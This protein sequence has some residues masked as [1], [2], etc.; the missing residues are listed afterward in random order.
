VERSRLVDCDRALTS[1]A[2]SRHG[3]VAVRGPLRSCG[4]PL[5]AS[6]GATVPRP[7]SRRRRRT[8]YAAGNPRRGPQPR[9]AI[10]SRQ[11]R[12]PR[13]PPACGHTAPAGQRESSPRVVGQRPT[14]DLRHAEQRIAGPSMTPRAPGEAFSTEVR[15]L[16]NTAVTHRGLATVSRLLSVRQSVQEH[17]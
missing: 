15:K 16:G 13:W 9:P 10:P 5:T 12:S 14:G 17:A 6:G 7:S 2:W 11:A 8:P 1:S 4:E 3:S